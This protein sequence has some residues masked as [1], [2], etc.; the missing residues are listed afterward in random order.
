MCLLLVF[1][2]VKLIYSLV[3]NT[4][5]YRSIKYVELAK[6][7]DIGDIFFS[8]VGLL[9]RNVHWTDIMSACPVCIWCYAEY[10]EFVE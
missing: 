9:A 4:T 7:F 8:P 6:V 2:E 5:V 3:Y 10:I 1:F